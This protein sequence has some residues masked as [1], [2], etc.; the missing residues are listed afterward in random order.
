MNVSD[1]KMSNVLSFA[2]HETFIM[3]RIST[4]DMFGVH[5]DECWSLE[6]IKHT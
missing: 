4:H 1:M 3:K 6:L 2:L 5:Y